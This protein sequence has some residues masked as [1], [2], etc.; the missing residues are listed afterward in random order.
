MAKKNKRILVKLVG[1]NGYFKVATRNPKTKTDK[2][3][4]K[5]YNP[6]TRQHEL[7]K[8]AKLS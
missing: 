2:L 5:K 1:S 7:M 3:A 8:E 4:L 6:R